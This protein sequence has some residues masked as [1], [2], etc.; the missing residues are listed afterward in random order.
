MARADFTERHRWPLGTVGNTVSI[1]LA[2]YVTVVLG[3]VLDL[4]NAAGNLKAP[5][6]RVWNPDS[7]SRPAGL[8]DRRSPKV[9]QDPSGG[10]SRARLPPLIHAQ[11]PAVPAAVP[12]CHSPPPG[13]PRFD[14][15]GSWGWWAA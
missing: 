7:Q 13:I 3:C 10:L 9:Y 12:R 1:H 14:W 6:S 8:Q 11:M 2:L 5:R 4:T 15:P